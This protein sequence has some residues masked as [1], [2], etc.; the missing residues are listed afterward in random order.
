M[1]WRREANSLRGGKRSQFMS[2]NGPDCGFEERP[3]M[4]HLGHRSLSG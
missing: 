1:W 2:D 3:V 4:A